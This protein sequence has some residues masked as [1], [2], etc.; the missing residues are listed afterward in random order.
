MGPGAASAVAS[1]NYLVFDIETRVDKSLLRAIYRP[2]RS[3]TDEE[4]YQDVRQ[5]LEREHGSDF[6]PISFHV[7]I[8]VALGAVDEDLKLDRIDVLG[9]EAGNERELAAGFWARVEALAG[10]LLSFNGR[11]FDLPVLELQALRHG[12]EAPR[13]FNERNGQRYRYSD[14]HYDLYDFLSNSGVH[15]IRG[16]LDLVS[17]LIGLPGKGDV[18]GRDVQALWDA[19]KVS[20][21]QRYCRRDVVQT[22][23]LFL[24]VERMRGRIG[25]EELDALWSA[26]AVWR[27]ELGE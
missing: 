18:S 23:L 9:A 13:Y 11:G 12:I 26:A 24:R 5:Q 19:G 6:V 14:R 15:R 3:T 25:A 7:P 1:M 4:A 16:G 10:A 20:E 17:K 27:A 22:Y 8:C 21:I 2:N